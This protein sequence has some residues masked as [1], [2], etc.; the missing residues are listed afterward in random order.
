MLDVCPISIGIET[1]GGCFTKLV[2]ANTTIPCKKSEIFS[3]AVDN[4]PSVDINVLQGERPMAKDN[5]S[6]GLFRLDGIMPSKR[7]IPQVE[8]TF[9]IDANSIL[10]VTALDKA[11]NKEQSITIQNSGSLSQEEIDRIKREAEEFAE[12][13]KKEREIA[14][15]LNKGDQ[16]VFNTEKMIEEQ[17]DKLSDEN[18]TKLSALVE[19][20]KIAVKDK[21][22]EDINRLESELNGVWNEIATAMYAQAQ[23]E[24]ASETVVNENATDNNIQ[25]ANFEEVN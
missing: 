25:D 20:M 13:D 24:Q 17:A 5:K 8:V 10:T 3:T 4:Q 23:Q 2:E 22:V 19:Q 7:G 1:L 15:T 12:S 16:I 11:T 14:D 21:N 9:N 6:I 18:K